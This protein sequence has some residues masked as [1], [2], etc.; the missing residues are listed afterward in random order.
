MTWEAIGAIA[1]VI[2]LVNA[3]IILPAISFVRWMVEKGL[4]SRDEAMA[5]RFEATE[6]KIRSVQNDRL[7][8]QQ[9]NERI[10]MLQDKHHAIREE[11]ARDYIH[12]QDW[13]R[14]EGGRDVS[15]RHLREDVGELK[16]NIAQ[17]RERIYNS[18]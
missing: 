13:V 6:E 10:S 11:M 16:T 4:A 15:M 12:R 8:V 1:G 17:I 7:D 3:L 18:N 2:G 5:A 14:V 9:L